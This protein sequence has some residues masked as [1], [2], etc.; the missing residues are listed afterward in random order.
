MKVIGIN[1]SPRRRANTQTLV[2]SILDGAS[3]KGAE[4]RLVNLSRFHWGQG[5]MSFSINM[6]QI[7]IG[8]RQEMIQRYW[9]KPKHMVLG[10]YHQINIINFISQS[11]E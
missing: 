11:I 8:I 5:I 10:F 1:A 3:E 4:T 6:E 9:K 7:L 2:E